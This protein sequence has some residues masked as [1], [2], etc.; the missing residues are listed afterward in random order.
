M[1]RAKT[2]REGGFVLF[3]TTCLCLGV[4]VAVADWPQLQHDA[5]HTGYT[6][7]KIEAPHGFDVGWKTDFLGLT[8][9]EHVSRNVQA[10]AY[11]GRLFV[12]TQEG[13]L[14]ALDPKT[15]KPV[16]RF[17]CGEGVM[18]TAGAE[19]G[20]VFFATIKGSVYAVD[21]KTGEQIWRWNNAL[22]TGFSAAEPYILPW[23]RLGMCGPPPP[24]I[25][26]REGLLIT[27]FWFAHAGWGRLD[28]KT[29]RVEDVL[30]NAA[31]PKGQW[32]Q[33]NPGRGNPDENVNVS[34]AGSLLFAVHWQEGNAQFTG[35]YDFDT[36]KWNLLGCGVP[37]WGSP[38]ESQARGHNA[39]CGNN[40]ASI[41]YGAV[42]HQSFNVLHN[43]VPA[44]KR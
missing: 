34:A 33:Q 31:V 4:R 39:Q 12:P 44:K 15:G 9:P 42:Y 2:L 43:W 40:A 24:P 26:D 5:Q 8:P 25:V 32:W 30:Y 41:A 1:K 36:R 35:F 10:I 22:R 11:D 14:F 3:V 38:Y 28:L 20:R 29:Q 16:W 17:H 7:E 23:W 6:D 21:A 18:H 27:P 37:S 19:A 13:S